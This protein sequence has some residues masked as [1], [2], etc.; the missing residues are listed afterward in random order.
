LYGNATQLQVDLSRLPRLDQ[1][2]STEVSASS[3][4]GD[5][6]NITYFV[7]ASAGMDAA[8]QAKSGLMRRDLERISS[9]Y[10]SQYGQI[11]LLGA[12]ESIAPE[13]QAIQFSYYSG[14]KW[15]DSWDSNQMQ[16]LPLAVQIT[17]SIARP[18][19]KQGKVSPPGVY[20]IVVQ[21]LAPVDSSSATADA[22]TPAEGTSD[23]S[24][25]NSDSNASGSTTTGV[26]NS[27]S[28]PNTTPSGQPN[29]SGGGR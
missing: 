18:A 3:Q 19:D 17:I 16:Y 13:V 22:T 24:S 7:V 15:L 21:I 27:S 20:S 2:M 1:Y 23:T 11:D 9:L 4:L 6:R 26:T 14:E 29:T 10:A 8:G 28:G 12:A 25:S 5:M